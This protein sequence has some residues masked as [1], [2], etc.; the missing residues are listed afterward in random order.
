M[1]DLVV[2][3]ADSQARAVVQA[4]LGRW[5]ALGLRGPIEFDVVN[6]AGTDGGVRTHGAA[7]MARLANSARHAVILFD[8]DG[9]GSE[10]SAVDLEAELE[11]SAAPAWGDRL[12]CV[13]LEPELEEWVVGA[14]RTFSAVEE[15]EGVD[16]GAWWPAHGFP[17]DSRGKPQPVKD[18][19]DALFE[20][21]GARRT[22]ANFR[23]IAGRA[24]L[25]IE[26]CQSRSFHKFVER[27]RG[28]FG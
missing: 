18:A 1:I 12:A 22:A 10:A 26:R 3:V 27:L 16:A 11:R 4:V 17:S 14:T 19:V 6:T 15:L 24:S 13:V 28:W 9:C 8:H 25:K 5:Q 21:H 23:L 7:M 2:L 20:A